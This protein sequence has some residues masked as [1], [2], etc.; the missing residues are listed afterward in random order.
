MLC[1]YCRAVTVLR[2]SGPSL[3]VSVCASAGLVLL[4]GSCAPPA[5]PIIYRHA[6]C[7]LGFRLRG[8][9]LGLL[10]VVCALRHGFATAAGW[11]RCLVALLL[12]AVFCCSGVESSF[13]PLRPCPPLASI[14]FAGAM[15]H[16]QHPM[17]MLRCRWPWLFGFRV[18][19][20]AGRFLFG[21]CL[22]LHCLWCPCVGS[23][24]H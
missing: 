3:A 23:L 15:S 20:L 1:P 12:R 19:L 7:W 2:S 18:G 16:Q 5:A 24:P 8:F 6:N 10:T 17:N 13:P 22:C 14:K 9:H 21:F 11:P 4:D